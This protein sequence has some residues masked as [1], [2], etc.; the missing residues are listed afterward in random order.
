MVLG[1]RM[2]GSIVLVL[3]AAGAIQAR[4]NARFHG[5][6]RDSRTNEPIAKALVSIRD[7]KIE[8]TT[9][10]NGEFEIA[11]VPAGEVELYVTTVGYGLV[12]RK[13]E[14]Q[15]GTP[16]ELDILLGPDVLR[17]ADEV[18]VT[19][20]PFVTP[21]PSTL[22]DHTLTESELKNLT[23]VLVDDPLRSVQALPGVTAG[24]DFVGDFAVRGAGFH[25]IG[26]HMDGVL[27]VSPLHAVSDVSDGGS[28]SIFNGDVVESLTLYSSA[29]PAEYGDRTAGE[30]VVR[31]RDGNR[32]RFANSGL[33][34]ASGL[35]WTSEGPL[36]RSRK[37]SWIAS[38]RKSYLDYI[39]NKISDDPAST[40]FVFGFYDGFAKITLDPNQ[41]HQV[42]ISGNFAN[43]R[44]DQSKAA[45]AEDLDVNDFLFGDRRTRIALVDWRW[46]PSPRLILNSAIS[47]TSS[48]ANN[49]NSD[50]ETLFESDFRQLGLKNDA[51]FQAIPG[52]RV[53]A[54]YFARKLEHTGLRRRFNFTTLQFRTTDSLD[55]GAWQPGAYVQDTVTAWD[56]R[57]SLTY[58]VRFDR[59][60]ATGQNIWMPRVNMAV[61]PRRN[62]RVTLGY[63]QY[64]QFADF[65]QLYGEFGNPS[66]RAERSSHY[67]LGVEQLINDKTRIRVEGY[68][69]EDRSGIF[70]ARNEVRLVNGMPFGPR[71]GII[72]GAPLQNTLRGY[73]RGIEVFLQRR[74]ANKLLGWVSYAYGRSRVRDAATGLSWDGDFDQRH[75]FS[76]YA[77]YRWTNSLSTSLKY[78][79]GSN[80]PIAGFFRR[81][82]I[83]RLV[84][85]DQR[86]QIRMPV[87]SRLDLRLNKAFRF[88][89]WQLTL[90][91]E[92]LNVLARENARYTTNMD[93]TNGRLSVDKDTLF[94]VLPL[95]G[96]RIDF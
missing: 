52:N 32:Q 10:E 86:N 88:D 33:A 80:F 3:L 94:P 96:V 28:L 55:A 31:T 7:L 59:L 93:T 13:L 38:A 69:R 12:R 68:D 54:G 29:F 72:P 17:R 63:G 83:G 1:R 18:T 56:S 4:Q 74:S 90:Y 82:S 51:S 85:S 11:N 87:Y 46:I 92:V 62:T 64:S 15:A 43:S 65:V 79:Y 73:S 40:Q 20:S 9:D 50:R 67:V 76:V 26:F 25:S 16:L 34:S 30:L 35:G 61:S 36:G 77:S 66:L 81:D 8:T 58:G 89:R 14:V 21:E 48:Y 6:V 57:L 45:E 2:L 23:S 24:D 84:L 19:A 91:G 75:T 60:D 42:R 5:T 78:R 53:E 47:F 95:A 39:I 44:A 37:A 49:I 27:L 70:S 71:A 22:S 41:R